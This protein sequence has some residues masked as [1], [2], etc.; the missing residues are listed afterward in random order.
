MVNN[1]KKSGS[2]PVKKGA[3]G[4]KRKSSNAGRKV[5]TTTV[6]V[7]PALGKLFSKFPPKCIQHNKKVWK[8]CSVRCGEACAAATIT[9]MPVRQYFSHFFGLRQN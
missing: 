3:G 9:D 7:G 6:P 2:G 8:S 1:K 5:S 4:G